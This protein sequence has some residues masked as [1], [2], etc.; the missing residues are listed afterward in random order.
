MNKRGKIL[1][2]PH[3]A[4]GLLIIEGRQYQFW[5]D[6][7]WGLDV[8]PR[9]GLAVDVTLNSQDQIQLISAVPPAQLER[10]A[11]AH[12]KGITKLRRTLWNAVERCFH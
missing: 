8:H 3:A 6:E 7:T 4:P 12:Q 11:V 1:R 10:E 5:L 9:L 2:D